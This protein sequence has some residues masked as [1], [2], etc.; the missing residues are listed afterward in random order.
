MG[1]TMGFAIDLVHCTTYIC[2][3]PVNDTSSDKDFV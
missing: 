1:R 2:M 3:P